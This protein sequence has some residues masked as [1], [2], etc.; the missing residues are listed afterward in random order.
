[1]KKAMRGRIARQFR[2]EGASDTDALLCMRVLA[3]LFAYDCK[4]GLT[5]QLMVC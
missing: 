3:P 5:P 2:N 4:E 1:M